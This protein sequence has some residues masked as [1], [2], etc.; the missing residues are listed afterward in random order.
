MVKT[1]DEKIKTIQAQTLESSTHVESKTYTEKF[2]TGGFVNASHGYDPNQD[3]KMWVCDSACVYR[4]DNK[5]KEE[6]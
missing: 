2:S 3:D 5:I 6:Q 1:I 4:F